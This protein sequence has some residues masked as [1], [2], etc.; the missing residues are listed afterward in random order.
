MKQYYVYI[1]ANKRNGTLYT[2]VTNDL[3]KRVFEHKNEVI[4]GFTKK[5]H[6]DRLVYFETHNDINRAI[7]R[8]KTI[9]R[10]RRKW[11]SALIEKDNPQWDDL[12]CQIYGDIKDIRAET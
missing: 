2:G 3:R 11:K 9:K 6:V 8:E 1:L 7:R 12:Y 4:E 5:Y 10:W